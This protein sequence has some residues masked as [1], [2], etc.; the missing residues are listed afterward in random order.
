MDPLSITTGVLALLGVCYNVGTGLKK[1]YDDIE[2]VDETVAAII[3]D[4]KAL[5]KVLNT[6]KTSFDGVAGP[7]TGHVGAHWENIYSSLKDGNGALEGLYEVVK[8]VSRETSVLSGTRKQMRL[9]AAESKIGLFR[10]QIQ[11]FRDTLQLSMQALIL[12]VA[13]A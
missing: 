13:P 4:V 2:A 9:K 8:E 5:T 11:S 10:K 7:L 1:L 6:M 3:E 12:Y